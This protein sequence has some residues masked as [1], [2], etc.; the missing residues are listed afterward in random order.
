M[1]ALLPPT[2][3]SLIEVY[4]SQNVYNYSVKSAWWLSPKGYNRINYISL[5]NPITSSTTTPMRRLFN[6]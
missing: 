3:N 4:V 6:I 5:S 2:N 1:L